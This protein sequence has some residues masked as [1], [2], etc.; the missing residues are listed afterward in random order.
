MVRFAEIDFAVEGS[1][2]RRGVEDALRAGVDHRA[3]SGPL[4]LRVSSR[5][6]GVSVKKPVVVG[7]GVEKPW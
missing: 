4:A 1:R 5:R 7:P 3:P 2:R 6:Q